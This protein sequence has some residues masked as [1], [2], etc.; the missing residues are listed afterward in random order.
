[1]NRRW[2]P[3]FGVYRLKLIFSDHRDQ[4]LVIQD[5]ADRGNVSATG[6]TAGNLRVIVEK[7]L[8]KNALAENLKQIQQSTEE[9]IRPK[10]R[11]Q[12]K[13]TNKHSSTVFRR[14]TNSIVFEREKLLTDF[15]REHFFG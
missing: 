13:M 10:R 3:N 12:K 14:G 2:R 7:R 5:F 11:E 6:A 15:D 9:F 1:M 4:N 8:E